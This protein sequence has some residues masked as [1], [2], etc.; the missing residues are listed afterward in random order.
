VAPAEV[1]LAVAQAEIRAVCGDILPRAASAALLRQLVEER[2]AVA[3]EEAEK[4]G[5]TD[6]AEMECET[7]PV[8]LVPA[9]PVS[10]SSVPTTPLSLFTEA[11]ANSGA[12]EAPP[13]CSS[14]QLSSDL[15][16][17]SL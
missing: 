7:T 14:A 6:E 10:P 15:I 5:M 3:E 9:S 11:E 8:S 13:L 17:L 16:C 12:E 4:E 1:G 2:R